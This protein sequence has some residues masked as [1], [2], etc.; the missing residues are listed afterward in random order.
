MASIEIEDSVFIL[1]SSGC[2]Q[3]ALLHCVSSY[4]ARHADYNVTKVA[5]LR[6]R[7]NLEIGLSDHSDTNITALTSI[8]LGIPHRETLYSK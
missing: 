4:P 7:F 8:A 3:I 2:K 1:K 5:D 6:S